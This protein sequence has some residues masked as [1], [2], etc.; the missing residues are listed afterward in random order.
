M[1]VAALFACATP[2]YFIERITNELIQGAWN[3]LDSTFAR[4]RGAPR[5]MCGLLGR[6][7]RSTLQAS[8]IMMLQG[9]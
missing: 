3:R 7:P 5:S 9:E 6:C 4:D 1:C 2:V 8:Q